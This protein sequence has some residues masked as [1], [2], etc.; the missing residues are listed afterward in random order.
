M[1]ELA[2]P[3]RFR[4]PVV[5]LWVAGLLLLLLVV[6]PLFELFRGAIG[7]GWV[8]AGEAFRGAGTGA[9]VVNTLWTGAVATLVALVVGGT[10]AFI[11]ERLRVPAR[12]WLRLGLLIPLV[13]PPF[14]SAL[15]WA[16]AYGP[17]GLTD[18]AAGFVLPGLFGGAG[19]V[20]VIAVNAVPLVYLIVAAGLAT[21]VAPDLE[22]AARV[23]G[24]TGR[25]TLRLVT[26]PLLRPALLGAAALAFVVA[27]N[28]FGIPAVLGLPVGFGTMTTRIYQDLVRSAAPAAFARVLVLAAALVVV[29]VTV[30]ALADRRFGLARSIVRTAGP[31]GSESAKGRAAWWPA[32]AVWAY[33][34]FTAVVP[35]L[36]LLLS[37]LT[38]AVG[39]S[40]VPANWTLGNF[41]EALAGR[42]GSAL[43]RSVLLATVAAT[44]VVLLGGL[45]ASLA[46]RRGG[47]S[48]GTAAILTFA[49]P[50]SALAVAVL[51]AY[52]PWLRD[53]LLI[54]LVAY[55]AKFWALGH[56][57]I[58]GSADAIPP[59]L[60]RAARSG[61]AGPVTALRT[62]TVP[63]LRPA[64]AAAWA[65]VFLFAFHELTMSTL[66]YGPGSETLAVVILNLRQLGDVGVTSAMA[67]LLTSLVLVA[68]LPVLAIRRFSRGAS[69]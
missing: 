25:E 26:L 55:L 23:A 47:R 52:G 69:Q 54:I 12:N 10:T 44:L 9:V 66:L 48:I 8:S 39:L 58:A 18:D 38:R 42:Y 37:S 13:T 40:P 11:T 57:S 4:R 24:S 50:G 45:A 20:V 1:A 46:R 29:T 41:G 64:I 51:L 7:E 17:G 21:R 30:V 60:Y 28:S 68:F 43:G 32:L 35:L 65:I 27:V 61:G 2:A 16:Q 6:I 22:R 49:V 3:R 62:V 34:A 19:V 67:V 59:D 14:V 53:T 56:R 63:L 33:V 15:S 5:G 31:V 36:A